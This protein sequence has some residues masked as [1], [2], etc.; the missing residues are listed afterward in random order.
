MAI[1]PILKYPNDALRL[2]SEPILAFDE[3]LKIL[4]Q[5]MA[6]TM[7]DAQGAGLA[8][9]QIGVAKRLIVVAGAENDQPFDDSY[10]FL[11]NPEIVYSEGRQTYD[12]GCLSVLELNEKVNRFWEIEIKAQ[13]LAG[14]PIEMVADGRR[15][16]ILQ[17]EIDHLDGILFIDHLSRLKRDIYVRKLRKLIKEGIDE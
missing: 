17:H 2:K 11:V 6:E 3:E 9:P 7:I 16:V 14:E 13:N 12:E 8:A 4:A 10:F 1:R 5:D 15:A